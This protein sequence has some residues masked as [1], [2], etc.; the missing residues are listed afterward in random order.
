ME[1]TSVRPY[2]KIFCSGE[3][4]PKAAKSGDACIDLRYNGKNPF[5][6]LCDTIYRVPTKTFVE[7]PPEYAG[8]IFE[9]SGL[10]AMNGIHILGRII[11]PGYRGEIVVILARYASFSIEIERDTYNAECR[12]LVI[13]PGDRI[14]QIGFIPCSPTFDFVK[15]ITDLSTTERGSAGLG[16]TGK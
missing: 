12:D 8:I 10:G 5:T 14:A 15:S 4:K 9:R 6:V 3:Y 1:I 7:I 11:D 2:I 16:S 13:N